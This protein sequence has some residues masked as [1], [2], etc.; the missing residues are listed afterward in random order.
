MLPFLIHAQDDREDFL[1]PVLAYHVP[2]SHL[3]S[4]IHLH[5][6]FLRHASFAAWRD[7]YFPTL[8]PLQEVF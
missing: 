6:L 4:L 3:V 7:E 2:P 1:E 5:W 8:S